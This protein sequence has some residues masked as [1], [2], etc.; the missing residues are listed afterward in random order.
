MRICNFQFLSMFGKDEAHRPEAEGRGVSTPAAKTSLPLTGTGSSREKNR[1]KSHR[2]GFELRIRRGLDKIETEVITKLIQAAGDLKSIDGLSS[3]SDMAQAVL[4]FENNAAPGG[5]DEINHA[6]AALRTLDKTLPDLQRGI[7]NKDEEVIHLRSEIQKICEKAKALLPAHIRTNPD[8]NSVTLNSLCAERGHTEKFSAS[9]YIAIAQLLHEV[10]D[11]SSSLSMALQKLLEKEKNPKWDFLNAEINAESDSRTK[12]QK[13]AP[14]ADKKSWNA[15]AEVAKHGSWQQLRNEAWRQTRK[16][17]IKEEVDNFAMENAELAKVWPDLGN[18]PP[19]DFAVADSEGSAISFP[20][21]SNVFSQEHSE[22]RSDQKI[23]M[24]QATFSEEAS[25]TDAEWAYP[26]AS[27][28]FEVEESTSDAGEVFAPRPRKPGEV[29]FGKS[30]EAV[31]TKFEN[32]GLVARVMDESNR[33]TS[34]TIDGLE[35]AAASLSAKEQTRKNQ[36]ESSA[37]LNALY[38]ERGNEEELS[39]MDLAGLTSFITEISKN[40][41]SPPVLHNLQLVLKKNPQWTKW[42]LL[43]AEIHSTN[44]W[45]IEE[46]DAD[47]KALEVLIATSE[48]GQLRQLKDKVDSQWEM[49][50][51]SRPGAMPVSQ[52]SEEQGG[53]LSTVPSPPMVSE[54]AEWH[55]AALLGFKWVENYDKVHTDPLSRPDSA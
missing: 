16:K 13:P 47:R 52:S 26:E 38:A 37:T 2:S 43:N 31:F 1:F 22:I 40:W 23:G 39:M 12:G 41:Q 49:K 54:E 27:S 17:L 53:A 18:G 28:E 34:N 30:M 20:K 51:R 9:E 8:G 19:L 25:V 14:I 15:L 50:Y 46:L 35:E 4:N 7:L 5:A 32:K 55:E 45:E 24:D 44:R 11:V 21:E 29:I 33:F 36:A 48:L 6:I 42:I 3:M 10:R